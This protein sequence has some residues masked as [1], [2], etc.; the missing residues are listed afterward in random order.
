MSNSN[1]FQTSVNAQPA[2]GEPGDYAGTNVRTSVI[3]GPSALV[4]AAAGLVVG[5]FGWADP[6]TGLA[7]NYVPADYPACQLGFV[8]RENQGLITAFLGLQT[9]VAPGGYEVTLMSQGDFWGL[10]A[11]P[12]T[13]GK[14]AFAN[15]STGAIVL[16]TAG[17]GNAAN[18]GFTG[19]I[20]AGVGGNNSVL[21][22]TAVG[23][24]TNGGGL[25]AGAVLVN[26]GGA[27]GLP[28]GVFIV[29][30]LSGSAGGNGTYQLNQNLAVIGSQAFTAL[31]LVETPWYCVT[32]TAAAAS[33]TGAL[34]GA[35]NLTVT[36]IG[37]NPLQ[38]GMLLAG[39][40]SLVNVQ[41]LGQQSGPVGGNGVYTV[42]S[43]L[44]VGA[45]ALTAVGGGLAK[46][47]TWQTA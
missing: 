14:K 13:A 15:A 37:G 47:S 26:D 44:T 5:V 39:L 20:A 7:S 17:A 10:C 12:A 18:V 11:N 1:G 9:L 36:G 16:G 40:A 23:T 3:A 30:Q 42:N 2:P 22:V 35:G 32:S 25:A 8:H 6:L 29:S 27:T 46:I 24:V 28:G 38:P 19:S 21:T 43:E 4:A 41:V 33:F 34:D 31:A 45:T